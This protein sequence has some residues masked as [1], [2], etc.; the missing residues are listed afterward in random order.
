MPTYD[1]EC[2]ECS[3]RFEAVQSFQDKPLKKCP[4]CGRMKLARLISAGVGIIFKGSG[5][6][7]TDNRAKSPT[8]SSAPVKS[9]KQ[10]SSASPASKSESSSSSGETKAAPSKKESA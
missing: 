5:F 9:E 3:Y 10:E 6:Y 7:V 2:R 4:Q 8:S 1:Y